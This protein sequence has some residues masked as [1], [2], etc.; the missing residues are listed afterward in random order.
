MKEELT[1]GADVH[2]E[3]EFAL[4]LEG[5]VQ[6]DHEWVVKLLQHAS[7]AQNRLDLVLVDQAILSKNFDGVQAASI[8]L[9][10]ED[11]AAET[12]PPNDPHLLE[13]VNADVAPLGQSGWHCLAIEVQLYS[14]EK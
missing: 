5:P 8:L 11:D 3:E 7:L 2:D 10:G 12:A 4:A 6:L 9:S 13:V 14:S 1:A